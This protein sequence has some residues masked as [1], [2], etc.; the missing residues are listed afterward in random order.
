MVDL[1]QLYGVRTQIGRY[2]ALV[3]DNIFTKH[4]LYTITRKELLEDER[5]NIIK[6]RTL[7]R[8]M[9]HYFNISFF[10][11]STIKIQIE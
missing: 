4:E 3:M 10:R 9:F 2:V 5:Y 7:I 8:L 1:L 6:G 11:S